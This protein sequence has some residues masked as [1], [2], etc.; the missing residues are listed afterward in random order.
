MRVN[1]LG[2]VKASRAGR[3]TF[4]SQPEFTDGPDDLADVADHADGEP[5]RVLIDI[6]A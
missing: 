5:D 3:N 1:A 6:K 4:S 2:A